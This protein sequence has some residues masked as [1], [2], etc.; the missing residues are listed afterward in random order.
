MDLLRARA[1]VA[2]LRR[3]LDAP[4]AL[5]TVNAL[6]AVARPEEPMHCLRP[7]AIAAASAAFVQ[8][9]PGETL[10]AVKCNPEPAVLR[11]VWEG[12]VRHFDCASAAEVSLV[13]A[14]FP[15]AGIHFMHPVKSRSAIRE[16][17]QR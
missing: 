9:F 7:A 17:W 13:R 12:G 11:A 10:Y 2:P 1:A 4:T 6:V 5:P 15:E 8:G 14:M 3:D 16:A